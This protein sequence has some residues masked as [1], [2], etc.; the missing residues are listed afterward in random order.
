M[1]IHTYIYIYGTFHLSR[2]RPSVPD[3]VC[4]A[5]QQASFAVLHS[6]HVC[7]MTQETRLL[8]ETADVPAV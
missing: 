1:H 2:K 4:F 3:G 8:C 5:T 6:R 7:C